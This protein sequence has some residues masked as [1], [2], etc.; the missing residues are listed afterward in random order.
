MGRRLRHYRQ[1]GR[2]DAVVWRAARCAES[3]ESA[4]GRGGC[5]LDGCVDSI[6][7]RFLFEKAFGVVE[8]E[9]DEV[10]ARAL[11]GWENIVTAT[12]EDIKF[13]RA[14]LVCAPVEIE[15]DMEVEGRVPYTVGETISY[16]W[17]AKVTRRVLGREMWSVEILKELN[18]DRGDLLKK[19]RV[20]FAEGK[21]FSWDEKSTFN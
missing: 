7:I 19:Y 11:G 6:F 1:R 21:G 2:T 10:V 15:G 8:R 20:M 13:V 4:G 3:I 14:K 16:G 5:K 18:N 12:V 17:L 9:G